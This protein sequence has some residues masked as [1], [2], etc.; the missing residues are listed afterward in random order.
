[1]E[2]SYIAKQVID[3][4]K[5]W[6][7]GARYSNLWEDIVDQVT[8][9]HYISWS[10]YEDIIDSIIEDKIDKLST[11]DVKLL[12]ESSEKKN[13][14]DEDRAPAKDE[15]LHDLNLI[16][17]GIILGKADE[18]DSPKKGLRADLDV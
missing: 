14:W 10:Y 6:T 17:R 3:E 4:L 9:Q 1:M 7:K 8:I 13:D 15:M 16:I 18:E 12:R 2:V 11:K 5:S